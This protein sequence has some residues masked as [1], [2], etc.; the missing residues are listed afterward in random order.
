[1]FL[2]KMKG[3]SKMYKKILAT[4]VILIVV[5]MSFAWAA[6]DQSSSSS[7][8]GID[9]G[10]EDQIIGGDKDEHGCLIAGGYSWNQTEEKC[11]KE[12]EIGEARYQNQEQVQN[13]AQVQDGE[14]MGEGG[15]MFRIETQE[16]SRIK[17]ESNGVKAEC[18][19]NMTQ[20]KDQNRTK[21][22]V[23]MSN[24]KNAE[25]KVMPDTASE[26][27]L[28]RLRLKV[29]SFENNCSIELKEVGKGENTQLA[30]ELK[31]Q[32]KAKFL[33]L[34]GSKMQ[35]KA[36]IA[37]ENGEVIK[38]DKPWWAFLASEPAEE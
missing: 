8:S 29:C 23:T 10:N 32:R 31:T 36:Q 4:F 7:G 1:M 5:C 6:Q 20:E 26:K 13:R 28:E 11:V 33:G 9:N 3:G 21:L 18:D 27:A 37:A 25:I 19:C 38:I 12:W 24:G 16:N 15:Q 22:K 14:H 35:V 17:L 30:Y 34:F 2:K